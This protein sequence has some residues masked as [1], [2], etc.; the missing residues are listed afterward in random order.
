VTTLGLG[1][2][3]AVA[4]AGEEMAVVDP[5]NALTQLSGERITGKRIQPIPQPVVS[6]G[7]FR[8]VLPIGENASPGV[9]ASSI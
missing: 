6:I 5:E 7:H 4:I 1:Q 2:A 8:S 9:R 3:V